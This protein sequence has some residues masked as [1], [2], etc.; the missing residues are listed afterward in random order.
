[1]IV[2]QIIGWLYLIAVLIPILGMLGVLLYA[3]WSGGIKQIF[4]GD[5]WL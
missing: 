1:M 2:L 5:Y 3:A 4:E